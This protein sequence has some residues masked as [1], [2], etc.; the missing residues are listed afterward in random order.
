TGE[1]G[2]P[3]A[4]TIVVGDFHSGPLSI[5]I[6]FGLYGAIAF[7]WFL[8]AGLRV[9]H[10]NWKFGDPALQRVNALLLAAFAGRTVFFFIFFGAL[11]SDIAFFAGLLGLSVALNG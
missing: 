1:A 9:L 5:L 10:R 11:H 6:P 4:G 2:N 8:A 7:L 3:L